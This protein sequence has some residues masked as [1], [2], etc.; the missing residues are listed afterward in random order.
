[1]FIQHFRVLSG[2]WKEKI[3]LFR[4]LGDSRR[5]PFDVQSLEGQVLKITPKMTEKNQV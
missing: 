2:N 1:M 3:V 4:S 5:D